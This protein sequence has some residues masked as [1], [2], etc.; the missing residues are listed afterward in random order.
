MSAKRTLLI[1]EDDQTYRDHLYRTLG[2][3]YITDLASDMG[4]AKILLQAK[5]HDAVLL[6]IGLRDVDRDEAVAAI[7]A[8]SKNCAIVVLSGN[9]NPELIGRMI[10]QSADDYLIKGRDDRNKPAMVARIRAAI[11]D[12]FSFETIKNAV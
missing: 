7:K 1:I 12:H 3:E 8:V 9:E 11:S 4:S 10:K 5:R 2:E 6:D